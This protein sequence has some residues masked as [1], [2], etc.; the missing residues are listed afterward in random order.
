MICFSDRRKL[1]GVATEPRV[2]MR[3]GDKPS[4]LRNYGSA[5]KPELRNNVGKTG[6]SSSPSRVALGP[7]LAT[8]GIRALLAPNLRSRSMCSEVQQGNGELG[9][10]S[11]IASLPYSPCL[12]PSSLDLSSFVFS[13]RNC[14]ACSRELLPHHTQ[15]TSLELIGCW[16]RQPPYKR[17][18]Q[19]KRVSGRSNWK[20]RFR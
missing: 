20:R 8:L 3:L 14:G 7:I 5:S 19:C 6:S 13:P 2:A 1:S 17:R 9:M 15:I 18:A 4:L 16:I 10:G 12:F 11:R